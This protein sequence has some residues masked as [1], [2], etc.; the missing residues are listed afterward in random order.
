MLAAAQRVNIDTGLVQITPPT[1]PDQA[2]K[3]QEIDRGSP[4]HLDAVAIDGATLQPVDG[5]DFADFSLPAKLASW[6]VSIHMGTMFGLANQVVML[7]LA[8][9]IAG[10][11]VL[12]YV[13][14]GKNGRWTSVFLLFLFSLAVIFV[15]DIDRPVSGI[16]RESQEPM[17]LLQESLHAS[18]PAIYDRMKA[19]MPAGPPPRGN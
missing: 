19:V 6:G 3:V 16:V 10:M 9:G 17:L 4:G 5:V 14:I 12:G 1:A 7:L 13:M 11:V 2:W 18:P 8:V 15:I